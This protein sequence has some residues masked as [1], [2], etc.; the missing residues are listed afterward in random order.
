MDT[1]KLIPA[2]KERKEKTK[3]EKLEAKLW[4]RFLLYPIL[5]GIPLA[6]F[7][8]FYLGSFNIST[9]LNES[10]TFTPS[11]ETQ[12]FHR[13][14]GV[15][16]IIVIAFAYICGLGLFQLATKLMVNLEQYEKL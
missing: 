13:D 4:K 10:V 7:Q 3:L 2:K 15:S 5:L 16:A 11:P 14:L 8:T 12:K 6:I 9:V 1:K